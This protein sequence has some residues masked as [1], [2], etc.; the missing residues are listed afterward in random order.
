MDERWESNAQR[1]KYDIYFSVGYEFYKLNILEDDNYW[2]NSDK[3]AD[4]E[5]CGVKMAIDTY[6]WDIIYNET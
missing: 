3:A 2:Y 5:E 1:F 4:V 6:R